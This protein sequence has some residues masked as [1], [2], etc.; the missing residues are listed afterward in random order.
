MKKLLAAILFAVV[1]VLAFADVT[2]TKRADGRYDIKWLYVN[3][4]ADEVYLAGD[5]TN[6]D[7]G[8]ALMEKTDEGW[9]YEMNVPSGTVFKY[10]FI[11]DGAWVSDLKAPAFENDGLGGRNGVINVNTANK[12]KKRPKGR[13]P[14]GRR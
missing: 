11:A 10:K 13:K 7:Q 3:P 4:R 2:V 6:W 8:K 5:F 1:G 9:V 14:R 12:P